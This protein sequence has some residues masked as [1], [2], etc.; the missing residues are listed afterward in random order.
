LHHGFYQRF[1]GDG[2]RRNAKNCASECQAYT[3][4]AVQAENFGSN[5]AIQN[6]TAAVGARIS[7]RMA[8]LAASVR[9]G[10]F[11]IG[12][13]NYAGT[14]RH[15]LVCKIPNGC[16]CTD[17]LDDSCQPAQ[18]RPLSGCRSIFEEQQTDFGIKPP[19]K[20][21]VRAKDEVNLELSSPQRAVR[22]RCSAL[23][24]D[25]TF[26]IVVAALSVARERG[27]LVWLF[28]PR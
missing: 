18:R 7:A 13:N 2:N 20:A 3:A 10:A 6:D 22:K 11:Q 21:G 8:V 15:F 19:G 14:V 4:R 28:L 1:S 17:P 12:G 25:G 27:E 16:G 24:P 9:I 26:E 5:V 23:Q